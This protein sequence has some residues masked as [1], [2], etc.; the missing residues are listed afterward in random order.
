MSAR[1]LE[2]RLSLIATVGVTGSL[3]YRIELSNETSITT[4]VPEVSSTWMYSL[5][6]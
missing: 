3:I 1:Y 2:S 5:N 6:A 4:V